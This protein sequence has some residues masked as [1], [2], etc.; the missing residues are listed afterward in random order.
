[1]TSSSN[2]CCVTDSCCYV[3][4]KGGRLLDQACGIHCFV[5]PDEC[6]WRAGEHLQPTPALLLLLVLLLLLLIFGLSYM[7]GA[8][9]GT[10]TCE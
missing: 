4:R 1:V 7:H 10:F 2:L 3:C 8:P 5:L 6:A 9:G